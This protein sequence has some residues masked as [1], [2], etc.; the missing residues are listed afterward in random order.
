MAKKKVA[1]KRVTKK[2]VTKRKAVKKKVTMRK[3]AARKKAPPAYFLSLSLE[4]V[5]CFGPVR[6]EIDLSDGKGHPRQW[7]VI[8]G[9]NN[10]GKSTLL[11]CFVAMEPKVL[12]DGG[13]G[14]EALVPAIF[15][16]RSSSHFLTLSRGRGVNELLISYKAS[17]GNKLGK[18]AGVSATTNAS[19]RGRCSEDGTP[20]SSTA[21][22]Q[23]PDLPGLICYGYGASRMMGATSL[24]ERASAGPSASLFEDDVELLNAEEWLLRADYIASRARRVKQI[25]QRAEEKRNQVVDVLT[26]LLPEVDDIRFIEPTRKSAK[27]GI[28]FETPYG[29]VRLDGLSLGY[30]TLIAWMVDFASR[31]FERY[32][33]S[34]NPLAEPAIVLVDEIDL[35]LHPKWQRTLMGYL[36]ERF[37]NTQFI[38]TAHSPLVVQA[39]T[40][41][42]VVLLKREG[43]HVV[44][45]NNP[46]SIKGWRADQI[47]SSDLFGGLPSR[48]AEIEELQSRRRKILAKSKLTKQDQKELRQIEA[49]M[50]DVPALETPE[51]IEAM[52]IIRQAAKTLNKGGKKKK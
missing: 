30:K 44:I 18:R 28:E 36:S 24:A 35:H 41:A 45:D 34:T 3:A 38:V 47:L 15:R 11:Q 23:K 31:M 2:K 25:R 40:D 52:N 51:D 27:P 32:P 6:Q 20:V 8:L 1:K 12:S 13:K 29:W 42:N 16:L 48:S 5:R 17:Y 14:G 9:D 49:Q 46:L 10:T 19:F 33:N 21:S 50:G 39:A 37:K 7:T 22:V 26:H 43:D 4:N